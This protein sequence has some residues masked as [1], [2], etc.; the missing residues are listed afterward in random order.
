M[1]YYAKGGQ[2]YGIKSLARELPNYGRYNDDMVAHISSEEAALLKALGGAGTI[3]PVTGLPEYGLKKVFKSVAQPIEK[4]IIRPIG[5]VVKPIAQ[6]LGI[7]GQIAATYFGGPIGAGLYAGIAGG[8]KGFD[9]KRALMA[10]ALAYGAQNLAQGVSDASG[11][12]AAGA[13]TATTAST[14]VPSDALVPPGADSSFGIG[15]TGATNTGFGIN[16]GPAPVE[17]IAPS[18]ATASGSVVPPNTGT[19]G[20]SAGSAPIDY[21]PTSF[22]DRAGAAISDYGSSIYEKG[23]NLPENFDRFTTGA[24]KLLTGDKAAIEAFKNSGVTM[25]NTALPMFVGYTG[26]KGIDESQKLKDEADLANAASEAERAEIL[27]RIENS[28]LRGVEA[29]KANPYR[30][31]QGGDVPSL[32]NMPAGGLASIQGMRDGYAPMITNTGDMPQ[33]AEGGIAGYS[34]DEDRYDVN[35]PDRERRMRFNAQ[36]YAVDMENKAVAGRLGVDYP[37]GSTGN[38][39]AG[40]G[41]MAYKTPE[42]MRARANSMDIGASGRVGPGFARAQM[43]RDLNSGQKRYQVGYDI[44]FAE[45]GQARFLSGGGDGM[46]DDIPATI[47]GKQPARLADGEFVVPADVVSHLGNGSSKAG[48]KKLYSMMDKVRTARTGTKKQGKQI[49]PARFMPA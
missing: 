2:P 30:F 31:A 49:N 17:G 45:G 25:S 36:P 11:M 26:M 23:A 44:P 5:D 27:A 33:Y 19:I 24:G 7:V 8:G 28:R 29:M 32:N 38:I 13:D 14:S 15:N 12:P 3:N 40:L 9:F 46:S 42:G 6:D 35:L 18:G 10:G 4:A 39:S 21:N 34:R 20:I 47:E 48:A 1:N 43:I 16:A 37:V 22:L 41:G